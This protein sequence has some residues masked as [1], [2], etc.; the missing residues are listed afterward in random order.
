MR[1]GT[2]IMT[3]RDSA[4][5]ENNNTGSVRNENVL[6]NDLQPSG[7]NERHASVRGENQK[8]I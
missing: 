6:Q 7:V 2:E 3:L 5:D 1:S 8:K 4:R